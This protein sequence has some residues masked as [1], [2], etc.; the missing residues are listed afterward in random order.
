MRLTLPEPLQ[1]VART[2]VLRRGRK[3]TYFGGRGRKLSYF[4][5]CDYFRLA[6]HPAVLEAWRDGLSRYGSNVAASRAT[7]GNHWLYETLEKRLAQFFGVESV[8]LVSCGYLANLV[9]AQTLAGDYSQVLID[10]RSHASLL[11][12][13]QLFGCPIITFRHRSAEAFA[14]AWTD[15]WRR[16]R[17]QQVCL[18][19]TPMARA[20]WV[21]RDGAP[22]STWVCLANG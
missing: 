10:E 14:A 4:G 13:A 17:R 9:V 6:S 16:C 11:D 3:L 21:D 2:F 19:M 1:Q 8:L 5:G 18:W 7:T 22:R 20:S 12:A 15:T